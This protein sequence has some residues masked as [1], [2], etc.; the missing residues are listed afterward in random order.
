MHPH[1]KRSGVTVHTHGGGTKS[2]KSEL[3]NEMREL[4]GTAK[5][6]GDKEK[7]T[8]EKLE[9]LGEM[10]RKQ[11]AGLTCFLQSLERGDNQ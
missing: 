2:K 7:K 6:R 3:R 11:R 8:G 10:R 9:D 1:C 4:I 5:V